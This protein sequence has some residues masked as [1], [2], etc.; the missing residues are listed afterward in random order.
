[1]RFLIPILYHVLMK[2]GPGA[3]QL[4]SSEE[5]LFVHMARRVVGRAGK[6]VQQHYGMKPNLS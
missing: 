3:T 2:N 6:H 5:K 4:I 1:M